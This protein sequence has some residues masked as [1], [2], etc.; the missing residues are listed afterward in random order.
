V[1]KEGEAGDC[2]PCRRQKMF[3]HKE[4]PG[5]AFKALFPAHGGLLNAVIAIQ[6]PP[7]AGLLK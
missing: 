5:G 7:V 3:A 6:Q 2:S 1:G 4:G